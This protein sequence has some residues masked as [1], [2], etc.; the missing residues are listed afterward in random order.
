[1]GRRRYNPSL[2]ILYLATGGIQVSLNIVFITLPLYALAIAA[3]AFEIGVMGALGG[4]TYSLMARFLGSLSDRFSKKSFIILGAVVQA[5]TSILYVACDTPLQLILVRII[6]S[7]GLALFW[8]VIEALVAGSL[9][10]ALEHALV[11]YNISWGAA[12][13]VGAPLAGFLITAFSLTL[14]FYVSS[15]VALSISIVL[16][17]L[18]NATE[19]DPSPNKQSEPIPVPE[20]N[21]FIPLLP[22]ASAFAYAFNSG[23]VGTLFPVFASQLRIPAYQI[24]LLFLVPSLVQTL[25]FVI[26][27][28][29]LRKFGR[30]SFLIGGFAFTISLALIAIVEN[31]AI[32]AVSFIGLGLGQGILFSSSLYYLLV[33]SDGNRG[34]AT[35]RFESILGLASFLGPFLGGVVAQFNPSYPYMAGAVLS[36]LVLVLQL[37]TTKVKPR[38]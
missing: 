3:S 9:K 4:L 5:A 26:S 6:Q 23:I 11:G 12:S 10:D 21:S 1:M 38:L 24:G 22:V 18:P 27:E 29:L 20:N 13:A 2:A 36:S 32:F 15:A 28:R 33:E 8:P 30:T 14:P 25:V 17:A 7:L 16:I 37:F 35:G 34:Q 19:D 31:T